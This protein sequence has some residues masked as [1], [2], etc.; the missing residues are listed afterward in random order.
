ML[1]GL[2]SEVSAARW[3]ETYRTTQGISYI[4]VETVKLE[5]G[6]GTLTYW[7]KVEFAD[8]AQYAITLYEINQT[9]QKMGRMMQM[10]LYEK[11]GKLITSTGVGTWKMV[12]HD[13]YWDLEVKCALM[14]VKQ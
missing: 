13:S 9:N 6:S 5:K 12:I 4:D 14:V 10:S 7:N 1:I 8:P 3:V 11:G 2:S